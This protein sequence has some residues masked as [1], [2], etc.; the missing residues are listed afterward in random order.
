VDRFPKE[1]TVPPRRNSIGAALRKTLTDEKGS[2]PSS[3]V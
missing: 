2:P 3:L 1:A